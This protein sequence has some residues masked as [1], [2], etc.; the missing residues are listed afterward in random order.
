MEDTPSNYN[1]PNQR[2][3]G[4]KKNVRIDDNVSQE[5]VNGTKRKKHKRRKKV[6][7]EYSEPSEKDIQMAKAYGGVAR[8]TLIKPKRGIHSPSS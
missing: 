2:F 8:G 3:H 5:G 6:V 7:Q 4:S 1:I